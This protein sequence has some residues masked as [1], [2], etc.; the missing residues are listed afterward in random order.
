MINSPNHWNLFQKYKQICFTFPPV[1]TPS[2]KPELM[3]KISQ[4][5]FQTI[6][7]R[8]RYRPTTTK[9]ATTNSGTMHEMHCPSPPRPR[10]YVHWNPLNSPTT[11]TLSASSAHH[12]TPRLVY[13]DRDCSSRTLRA[14]HRRKSIVTPCSSKSWLK[15][16]EFRKKIITI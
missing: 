1:H 4:L 13:Y 5:K 11:P 15:V 10:L 14:C 3:W 6:A 7:A 2:R 16:G 8:S 9:S 12:A